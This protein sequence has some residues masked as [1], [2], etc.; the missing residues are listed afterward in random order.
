MLD[1]NGKIKSWEASPWNSGGSSAIIL[2]RRDD[3]VLRDKVVKLLQNLK[4]D[5]KNRIAAIAEPSASNVLMTDSSLLSSHT[6]LF[7]NSLDWLFP[8]R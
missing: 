8:V 4:A 7:Y 2:A 6:I 1:G 3:A 5:S